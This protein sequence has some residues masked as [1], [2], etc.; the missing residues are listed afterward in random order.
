MAEDERSFSCMKVK[1][2]ALVLS[3]AAFAIGFSD[4][5]ENMWFYSGRPIGAILFMIFMVFTAL[6]KVTAEY[7]QEHQ[8]LSSSSTAEQVKTKENRAPALTMASSH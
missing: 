7:D 6:D 8:T 5:Q 2:I 1:N 3:L 4:A